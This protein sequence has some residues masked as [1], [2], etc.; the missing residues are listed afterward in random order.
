MWIVYA[1]CFAIFILWCILPLKEFK[2]LLSQQ[3]GRTKDTSQ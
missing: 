1:C 2:T 3:R